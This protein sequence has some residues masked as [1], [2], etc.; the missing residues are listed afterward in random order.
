[1]A[2]FTVRIELHS[3]TEQS[4]R[5]LHASTAQLGFTRTIRADNGVVY[6]LPSAEYH[7]QSATASRADVLGLARRAVAATGHNAWILVTEAVGC[8]FDLAAA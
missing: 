1:M 6:A 3:A 8:T 7:C 5:L 2:M 4:Y